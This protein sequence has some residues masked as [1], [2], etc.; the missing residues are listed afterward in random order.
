MNVLGILDDLMEVNTLACMLLTYDNPDATVEDVKDWMTS[1]NEFLFD[2]TPL[3][4]CMRGD[5]DTLIEWLR[6]RMGMKK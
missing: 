4:V 2:D 1:S 3:E 6:D 5:A